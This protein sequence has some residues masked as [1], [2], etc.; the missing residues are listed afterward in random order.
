MADF[1]RGMWHTSGGFATG[2]RISPGLKPHGLLQNHFCDVIVGEAGGIQ[3]E[4][5]GLLVNRTPGGEQFVEGPSGIFRLEKRASLAPGGALEKRIRVGVQPGNRTDFFHG[6]P[7][8]FPQ[9]RSSSG[10]QDDA[11]HADEIGQHPLLDLAESLLATS[12]KY[13][14]NAGVFRLDHEIIGIYKTVPG[15]GGETAADGRFSAAHEAD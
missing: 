12:C 11:R 5:R 1:I 2:I 4:I 8:G 9:D 10:R 3:P 13:F 15:E 7:V 14:R 6:D